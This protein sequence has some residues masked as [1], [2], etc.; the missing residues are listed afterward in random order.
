M[1]RG[2]QPGNDVLPVPYRSSSEQFAKIKDEMAVEQSQKRI[3]IHRD[4]IGFE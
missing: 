3:F 4:L 1:K 2:L